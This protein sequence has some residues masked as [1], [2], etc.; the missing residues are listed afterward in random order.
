MGTASQLSPA[1]LL[2]PMLDFA[3]E[4]ED[5]TNLWFD[6]DHVPERV[7]CAGI[8]GCQ[9]FQLTPVE[10]IGWSPD[11]RWTKYLH[12][13]SLESIAVLTSAGY[14]RQ[15]DMNGGR[16][17]GWR[18][19][20][21]GRQAAAGRRSPVRSL[22]TSWVRRP[23]SWTA[24]HPVDVPEP[25]AILVTLRHDPGPMDA[26]VN[27]FLDECMMP[28]LLMLPGFL[29]CERYEASEPADGFGRASRGFRHPRYLDIYDVTTPEV[30]TSGTYRRLV[31]S[32]DLDADLRA[33]LR[34]CGMGVYVQR[35]SAW[36][37][38]VR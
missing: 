21:E 29:G 9:R 36:R 5:E 31:M 20:R 16:G 34:P 14:Q 18:Q 3:A 33:A 22:R 11:Q 10:P 23:A 17:S 13:Y 6:Y 30:L 2:V 19:L 37:M 12:V 26:A 8:L 25:R 1:A 28:E 27:E 24:R 35:P 4:F 38:T 15:R 32:L 7:S